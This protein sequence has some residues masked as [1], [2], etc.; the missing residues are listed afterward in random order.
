MFPVALARPMPSPQPPWWRAIL[1]AVAAIVAA[2]LLDLVVS[3]IAAASG[4]PRFSPALSTTNIVRLIVILCGLGALVFLAIRALAPRRARLVWRTVAYAA[5]FVSFAPDLRMLGG[6][7]ANLPDLPFFPG[8]G[9]SG[10]RGGGFAR[11]NSTNSTG[12]ARASV[13][14]AP[15]PSAGKTVA[16]LVV[17][18]AVAA[19]VL[20]E[21]LARGALRPDEGASERR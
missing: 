5:M 12:F 9:G 14:G 2:V 16:F 3:R 8:F 21:A 4:L 13:G 1:V 17:M 11:N 18:H 7:F 10:P 20:T 19:I 15:F 6:A